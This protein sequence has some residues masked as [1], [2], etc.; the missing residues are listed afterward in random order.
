MS[1]SAMNISKIMMKG[2]LNALKIF[3]EKN[4]GWVG[5]WVDIGWRSPLSRVASA[6]ESVERRERG[7]SVSRAGS[8]VVQSRA[9][10]WLF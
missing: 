7:A 6:V 2:D 8:A 10:G 5:E 3:L 4:G 1:K 9:V